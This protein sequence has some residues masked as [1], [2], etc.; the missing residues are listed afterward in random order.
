M[1]GQVPIVVHNAKKRMKRYVVMVL[2]DLWRREA[3]CSRMIFRA[4]MP[5]Q[6]T[7]QNIKTD[8]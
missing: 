6:R 7:I 1:G 5:D 3:T 4:A 2:V 8:T